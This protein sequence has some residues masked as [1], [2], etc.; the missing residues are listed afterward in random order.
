MH[1]VSSGHQH[2]NFASPVTTRLE[3]IVSN[4]VE[5]RN[6]DATHTVGDEDLL[7]NIGYK[8][9]LKRTFSTFQVFGI[10]YSID[11]KSVV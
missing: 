8:Q 5:L 9:E 7:A 6:I 10:A 3:E 11:R 4:E 1:T 2:H